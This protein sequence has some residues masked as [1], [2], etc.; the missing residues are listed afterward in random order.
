MKLTR[1]DPCWCGSGQKYKLCH[2]PY[3]EAAERAAQAGREVFTREMVKTPRQ[4]E[5]IAESAAVNTA[6]LDAVSALV[7]PGICTAEIDDLVYEVTSAHKAL[8]A[9]LNYQG[10]PK[11][12]CTSANNVICHG[13]PSKQHILQEG[14]IV[15]VDVSTVLNGYF[16]DASRMFC[17]GQVSPQ[18]AKLV[19]VAKECLDKGFHAVK[20]GGFTGDIAEAVQTHAEQNG[21]SVVREFGGHGVGVKF[22]ED[23]FISHVGRA[24]TGVLLAPGMIFTIEPM[25]NEG[26]EQLYIDEKDQWTVRTLDGKFSAQWEYTVLVT[27]D[28]AKILTH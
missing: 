20:P 10:F 15:N 3:D 7:R 9:P 27:P 22:H 21:F 26:S 16:S 23:P 2:L 1:N 14:D 13:I 5:A 12:V 24:G 19:R 28:G 18:A 4:I 8:P 25:I 17:I 11:S 6:V